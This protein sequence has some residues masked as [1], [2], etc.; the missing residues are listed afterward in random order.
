[1]EESDRTYERRVFIHE[2]LDNDEFNGNFL[3]ERTFQKY[4][5]PSQR[6]PSK[7]HA[8]VTPAKINPVVLSNSQNNHLTDQHSTFKHAKKNFICQDSLFSHKSQGFKQTDSPLFS[9]PPETFEKTHDLHYVIGHSRPSKPMSG[10]ELR[11]LLQFAE[12]VGIEDWDSEN[13]LQKMTARIEELKAVPRCTHSCSA[14]GSTR[15]RT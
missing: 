9:P 14:I 6:N 1:M 2:E 3:R 7:Q 11:Y 8:L 13:Y 4:S 10:L 5:T 15:H 12:A